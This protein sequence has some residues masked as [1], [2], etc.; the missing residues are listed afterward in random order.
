MRSTTSD[1]AIY[2]TTNNGYD[3]YS[4]QKFVHGKKIRGF[5]KTKAIA[6][7]RLYYNIAKREAEEK[8]SKA[9]PDFNEIATS[10]KLKQVIPQ[11][12]KSRQQEVRTSTLE[13]YERNLQQHVVPYLG[14]KRI[15][16]IGRADIYQMLDKWKAN[17]LGSS[18]QQ[19]TFRYLKAFFK[20]CFKR[21]LIKKNPCDYVDPP[22]H[23]SN[24]KTNDTKLLTQR[25]NLV[26]W[27][28]NRINHPN[29]EFYH[30][31]FRLMVMLLG[32]RRGELLGLPW[33]NVKSLG[34]PKGNAHI[35]INQQLSWNK[36]DGFFIAKYLKNRQ[37]GEGERK[38]YLP[39]EIRKALLQYKKIRPKPTMN[40]KEFNDL[41]FLTPAGKFINWRTYSKRWR[42]MWKSEM[43]EG[44]FK[45]KY[46]RPHYMRH[47]AT[48]YLIEAGTPFTVVQK[49]IG[50]LDEKTTDIYAHASKEKL[51]EASKTF[52]NI[53]TES[54]KNKKKEK[55]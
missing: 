10:Q 42:D 11:Y 28:I 7:Q 1:I 45:I 41:V 17:K 39:E 15:K 50:H 36:E 8:Y 12:I 51:Q 46:F 53:I 16:S 6:L 14:E 37:E 24:V 33:K 29:S 31:Y 47:I 27:L 2:K 34:S 43:T 18:A 20:W 25:R 19:H 44:D 55:H 13:K 3:G 49:W 30:D 21:E 5:G 26:Y 23:R 40:D 38:I 22:T 32:L 35:V 48:S 54:S 52:N 4:A 9:Y